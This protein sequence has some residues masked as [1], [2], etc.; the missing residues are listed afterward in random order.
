[1]LSCCTLL[2]TR[3]ATPDNVWFMEDVALEAR[4][5]GI[6]ADITAEQPHILCLQE[7]C[8]TDA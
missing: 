5:R 6:G 8:L 1:L 7:V 4:M 2:L 3:R